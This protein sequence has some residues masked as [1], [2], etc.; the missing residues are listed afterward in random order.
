[1]PERGKYMADEDVGKAER[2]VAKE[3]K[4]LGRAEKDLGTAHEK[5]AGGGTGTGFF[6]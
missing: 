2:N 1:M 6:G 5:D 4:D 3:K